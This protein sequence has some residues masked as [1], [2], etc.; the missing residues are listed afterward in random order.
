MIDFKNFIYCSPYDFDY[1][2]DIQNEFTAEFYIDG[3]TLILIEKIKKKRVT[4]YYDNK[5][6][7]KEKI[8]T[9]LK[10]KPHYLK[11]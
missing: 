4:Y 3:V 6:T 8:K 11:R 2:C 9:K 10:E 7:S 5:R 1:L